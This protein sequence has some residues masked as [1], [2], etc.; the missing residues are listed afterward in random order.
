MRRSDRVFRS[1]PS[2][3]HKA[4]EKHFFLSR[5]AVVF[6][7]IFHQFPLLKSCIYIYIK[8]TTSENQKP[9]IIMIAS[10]F[11]RYYDTWRMKRILM[12]AQKWH[13]GEK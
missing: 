1:Q 10:V 12:H 3:Q 13:K 2:D 4:F 6:K 9:T 11:E 7:E 8:Q 5:L